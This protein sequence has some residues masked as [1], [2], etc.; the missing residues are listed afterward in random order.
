MSC[1]VWLGS[2]AFNARVK[3]VASQVLRGG[4]PLQR[5]KRVQRVIEIAECVGLTGSNAVSGCFLTRCDATRFCRRVHNFN[6]MFE[7]VNG[8][9]VHYIRCENTDGCR[10]GGNNARAYPTFRRSM[11]T[12]WQFVSSSLMKTLDAMRM[13]TDPKGGRTLTRLHAPTLLMSVLYR[14]LRLL[15]CGA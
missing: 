11:D 8:L 13:L 6:T 5:S 2:D 12:T 14:Q 9:D 7:L 3:W 1:C 15:S 10:V 4:T